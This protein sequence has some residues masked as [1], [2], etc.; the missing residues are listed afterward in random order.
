MSKILSLLAV[1][2]LFVGCQYPKI[3]KDGNIEYVAL[4]QVAKKEK[5]AF[6]CS[7]DGDTIQNLNHSFTLKANSRAFMHN[8][9]KM[10]LATEPIYLHETLHISNYDYQN[11]ILPLLGKVSLVA[12]P[13]KKIV[14]D[15]GHGAKYSGAVGAISMEKDLNLIIS[16]KVGKLLTEAGFEVVYTRE[17]DDLLELAPRAAWAKESGA[18]L[19][20]SIHCNAAPT[21]KAEGIETFSISPLGFSNSNDNNDHSL[22]V[23]AEDKAAG[24]A[25]TVESFMLSSAIQSKLIKATNAVD[26]GAKRARFHVL[27]HNTVPAALVECG[28]MSNVEEEKLLNNS[29]YT[30]LVAKSIVD[31][32]LEFVNLYHMEN[33]K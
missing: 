17:G 24:Y 33:R 30:D 29:E 18:D 26:R 32:I 7:E 25:N 28:F 9:V 11:T 6:K 31:G 16:K 4:E 27:Y 13:P 8:G 10:W 21:A 19:F 12:E 5:M 20:L 14:L 15:P 23:N 22:S 1:V 3:A 2:L